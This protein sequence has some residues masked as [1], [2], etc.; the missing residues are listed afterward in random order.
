[1]TSIVAVSLT[2]TSPYVFKIVKNFFLWALTTRSDS[3]NNLAP[4]NGHTDHDGISS[5]SIDNAEEESSNS[6]T[7]TETTALIPYQD[8]EVRP[9]RTS[10]NLQDG[11]NIRSSSRTQSAEKDRD[12]LQL[13][14]DSESSRDFLWECARY[15]A[16]GGRKSTGVILVI[17]LLLFGVFVT[18]TVVGVFSANIATDRIGISSSQHCGI[19]QFDDNAGNEAGYRDDLYNRQK[20]ARASQ[21]A[22]NC[23]HNPSATDTLSCRI[24]YNQSI[25]YSTKTRQKC[26]FSSSELCF[27]GLYS[28]ISFDTGLIDASVIGINS[29]TTYKI[30]RQT[31]CSPLNISEPYVIHEVGSGQFYYNYGSLDDADYTF[32]TSGHPFEWHVPVYSA[33]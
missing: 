12:L 14:N 3:R 16:Q 23:Y 5:I 24:F 9:A 21:Y 7:T 20:E 13:L 26:P 29:P 1:M 4:P 30:R 33:K 8:G 32:N 6:I 17:I 19:W 27:D 15:V 25:Q 10:P 18:W 2:L 11:P 31:I 28:A 22:R